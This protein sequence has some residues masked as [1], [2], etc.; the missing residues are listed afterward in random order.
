MCCPLTT[1]GVATEVLLIDEVFIDGVGSEISG[2]LSRGQRLHPISRR[3]RDTSSGRCAPNFAVAIEASVQAT[4]HEHSIRQFVAAAGSKHQASLQE[5]ADECVRENGS[6]W[7]ISVGPASA[8]A[9]WY[10]PN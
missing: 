10:E 5:F 3:A 6:A 7:V 4:R 1:R 2:A 9:D 8:D